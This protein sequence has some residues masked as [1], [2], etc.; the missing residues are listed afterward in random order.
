[1]SSPTLAQLYARADGPHVMTTWYNVTAPYNGTE[2]EGEQSLPYEVFFFQQIVANNIAVAALTLYI[3]EY[4]STLYAEYRLYKTHK[5]LSHHVILFMLV[6]YGTI[7]SLILPAYSIWHNFSSDTGGCLLH[8]QVS[9]CVVQLIVSIVFAWRTIAIWGNEKRMTIFLSVVVCLQFGASFGL[10]WFSEEKILPNG[11]CQAVTPVSGVNTL[12]AFYAIAFA[13]DL[14]TITLSTYKLWQFSTYGSESQ[15]Y[16]ST[17]TT[18]TSWTRILKSPRRMW[19]GTKEHW[20]V[21]SLSPLVETLSRA[22]LIYFILATAYNAISFGL[23]ISKDIHSKALVTLYAPLMAVS[24]QRII[25]LDVE[26]IWGASGTRS[27]DGEREKVLVSRVMQQKRLSWEGSTSRE[28]SQQNTPKDEDGKEEDSDHVVLQMNNE[29]AA[30]QT[31]RASQEQSGRSSQGDIG[32]RRLSSGSAMRSMHDF[33]A[34]TQMNDS[35]RLLAVRMAGLDQQEKP[36]SN[37]SP[38]L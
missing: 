19:Q 28:D 32:T 38:P 4:L 29:D 11:S 16:N 21:M 26:A 14:L 15:A 35:N 36:P 17:T 27:G 31:W 9:I 33:T 1:M 20:R 23:E 10:L 34:P 2:V 6:R 13:F 30:V 12:P 24:C 18:T 37:E 8:E 7:P 25:L 5:L 22:G 3:W